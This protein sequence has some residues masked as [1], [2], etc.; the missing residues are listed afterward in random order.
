MKSLTQTNV[1]KHLVAHANVFQSQHIRDSSFTPS[2]I[3]TQH[4]NLDH[5]YQLMNDTTWALLF[6]L[7]DECQLA[8]MMHQLMQGMPINASE[9][10]P[11]LHTALR[12]ADETKILVDGYNIIPE[13]QFAREQMQDIS[14]S[15]RDGLW[16]GYS[17]KA[18]TD[19]VSLGIGGS[20]LGPVFALT[21][22]SEYRTPHLGFHVVSD[23][24]AQNFK[25][26]TA[27]LNP[28]TTLFVVAS[29]SFT[30]QETLLNMKR[31]M[32]WLHAPEAIAQHFIAVT[33]VPNR[34]KSLGIKHILRMGDWIG[35]RYSFCSAINLITAIAIGFEA[36]LM[37]LDGARTMDEHFIQTD[38]SKNIPILLALMGIWNNNFLNI[39]QLVILTYAHRLKP[40]A[41]YVQQL[42]MESNGKSI[43]RQGFRVDYATSPVVFGG[44]GNQA[45][46]SYYQL[47]C[48]GTHQSALELIAV[49]QTQ[50]DL[51]YQLGMAHQEVL[52]L[53]VSGEILGNNPVNRIELHGITPQSIG[54][55]IALYEHKVFAQ[56]VIWNLN[57]FDQPGVESAKRLLRQHSKLIN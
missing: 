13:I 14:Q 52:A 40:F 53:G 9:Q 36:F 11:A 46:H 41:S 56:G 22:L 45:Q 35:G 27:S 48:Q 44:D 50:D 57:S 2:F 6:E 19:V 1:W 17:G 32:T 24:D 18:V 54:A 29:K 21:A 37:L 28:E 49:R 55:L 4:L 3:S 33:A 7:A 42:D 5:R 8:T 34:A 16:L 25:E 31:A 51:A 15:I 23:F 12:A 10:R 26:V 39:H 30:T 43:D 38:F 47:L 20:Y